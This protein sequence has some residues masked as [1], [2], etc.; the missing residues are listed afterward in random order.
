M[1]LCMGILICKLNISFTQYRVPMFCLTIQRRLNFRLHPCA[2]CVHYKFMNSLSFDANVAHIKCT[3]SAI[4]I[5]LS[6]GSTAC[7]I[8]RLEHRH[9]KFTNKSAH[10]IWVLFAMANNE[11]TDRSTQMHGIYPFFSLRLCVHCYS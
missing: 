8:K 5:T 7:M 6:S 4:C 3:T 9:L 11:A 2:R 1:L 10:R